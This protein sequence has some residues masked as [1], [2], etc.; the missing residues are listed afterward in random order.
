MPQAFALLHLIHMAFAMRRFDILYIL[1]TLFQLFRFSEKNYGRE[2]TLLT[3]TEK[4]TVTQ[5]LAYEY[6]F[7]PLFQCFLC[8]TASWLE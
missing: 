5:A 2:N 7:K 1:Y 6:I 4:E 3:R 8:C